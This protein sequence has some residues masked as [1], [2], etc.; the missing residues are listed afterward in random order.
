MID[1]H[2]EDDSVLNPNER[3]LD[4]YILSL[5]IYNVLAPSENLATYHLGRKTDE[6]TQFRFMVQTQ[7]IGPGN[8]V[9]SRNMGIKAFSA[10]SV[11]SIAMISKTEGVSIKG[12]NIQKFCLSKGVYPYCDFIWPYTEFIM[13]INTI[14][15]NESGCVEEANVKLLKM[16][17]RDLKKLGYEVE[18]SQGVYLCVKVLKPIHA[19]DWLLVGCYGAKSKMPY[20]KKSH[21]AAQKKSFKDFTVVKE[22]AKRLIKNV[23][24]TCFEIYPSTKRAKIKWQLT[25]KNTCTP[26]MEEEQVTTKNNKKK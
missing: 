8:S 21:V 25:H 5:D 24:P 10:L 26:H 9:T 1:E 18:S 4:G 14:A 15:V 17:A 3:E 13:K 11:H 19:G 16:H 22:D 23:C 6:R 7:G 20:G 12:L 2:E